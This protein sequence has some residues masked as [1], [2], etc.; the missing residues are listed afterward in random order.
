MA[1]KW[2]GY[3]GEEYTMSF[4]SYKCTKNDSEGSV[5]KNSLF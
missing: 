2:K 1:A 3:E 4:G 5:L